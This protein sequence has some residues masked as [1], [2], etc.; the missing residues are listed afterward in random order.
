MG[1]SDVITC[2][3]ASCSS[4]SFAATYASEEFESPGLMFSARSI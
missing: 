2:V 4:A 1:F 3:L